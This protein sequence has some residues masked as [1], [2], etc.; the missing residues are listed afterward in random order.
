VAAG[1]PTDADR[2]QAARPV[3]IAAI[4]ASADEDAVALAACYADDAVWLAADGV[5]RG[6][7]AV[8][9]HAAIAAQ[10]SEWAPLQQHGARAALR[11]TRRGRDGAVEA[12]GA[13]IVEVR[14]ER[15]IFA[16]T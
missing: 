8:E 15:I 2:E 7:G 3:L 6:A 16:A 13:I 11:W 14:R 5:V 9:R 1:H 12:S 4:E 10:A